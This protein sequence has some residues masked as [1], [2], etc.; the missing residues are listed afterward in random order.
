VC[1]FSGPL[2]YKNGNEKYRG[3]ILLTCTLGFIFKISVLLGQL[4]TF[5]R[6]HW[7]PGCGAAHGARWRLRPCTHS[8]ST[9]QLLV[10]NGDLFLANPLIKHTGQPWNEWKSRWTNDHTAPQGIDMTF[11]KLMRNYV[12]VMTYFLSTE[13]FPCQY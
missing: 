12:F 11:F 13:A 3:K 5:S 4:V 6:D 2:S 8:L 7:W 10:K 1:V 9:K